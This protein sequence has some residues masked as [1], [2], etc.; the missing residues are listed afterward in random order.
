MVS[1]TS[2][3][4][5][6]I[7]VNGLVACSG[8][9]SGDDNG[10]GVGSLE[11]FSAYCTGTLLVDTELMEPVGPG[12]WQSNGTQGTAAAGT[13]FLVET[14]FDKW[15]GYIIASSGTPMKLD[16]DF[17]TGLVK[18]T[19]F[20]SE[21]ATDP[22][23]VTEHKVLLAES[24]FFPNED[25]SGTPCKLPAA[26]EFSSFSFFGGNTATVMAPEIKEQC[27]LD[28]AY[29]ADMVYGSLVAK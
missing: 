29:S 14:S 5:V 13:V 10:P 12:G 2:T 27:G 24:T 26:T 1:R 8:S 15:D 11:A 17:Q 22:N 19:H 9:D 28:T 18:D 25:L 6:A 4:A 7:L 16:S 23:G 20:T 21:C 3:L